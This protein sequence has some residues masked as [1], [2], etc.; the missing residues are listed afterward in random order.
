MNGR[1]RGIRLKPVNEQQEGYRALIDFFAID[2][3]RSGA[4][5]QPEPVLGADQRGAVTPALI[6]LVGGVDQGSAGELAGAVEPPP[7]ACRAA[8]QKLA[9]LLRE[10]LECTLSLLEQALAACSLGST[11]DPP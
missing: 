7:P 4:L 8:R 5:S 11:Q 6:P 1:K 10:E 9:R 2:P 3:V